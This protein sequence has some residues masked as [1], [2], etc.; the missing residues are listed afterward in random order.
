MNG[1]DVEMLGIGHTRG[2]GGN[3]KLSS[4]RKFRMREHATTKLAHAYRLDEIAASVATMQSAS[5]LEEVAKH[6]LVRNENDPEAQYVHFFHEKIPSRSM[7]ENTGLQPLTDI[8]H[9]R[10][11]E[12]AA[13]RTRAVTRIFKEDYLGSV[14]DLT[15]GLATQRLYHGHRSDQLELILARDAAKLAQGKLDENDYP[16]SMEPQLL[17]HRAGVHLTLACQN[18]VAALRGTDHYPGP[19]QDQGEPAPE[20]PQQKEEARARMEA[21][22]L[23]RTYA[24]RALRDYTSFLSHFDYS[25]GISAEFTDAFLDKVASMTTH[26]TSSNSSRSQRLLDV[27]AHSQ[28]GLSEALVKYERCRQNSS[29]TSDFPQIP[30]PPVYKISDLFNAVP[31][32]L[33]PFPPPTDK[34][35]PQHP[36]FSLPD[37]SEAVTYHPLLADVLHSLLLCHCLVQ[38][39]QKELQR[40]AYM[41]A[42]VARACD[43]YPIFL[44]ARSPSRADWTE[45]LRKIKSFLPLE[46]SWENLCQPATMK[47]R[48][49]DRDRIKRDAIRDALADERVV[50]EET[51]RAS[52]RAREARAIAAEDDDMSKE[53]NTISPTRDAKANRHSKTENKVSEKDFLVSTER[54]ELIARWIREAP[55]PGGDSS[56]GTRRRTKRNPQI[57]ALRKQ[58]SDMSAVSEGSV[59]SAASSTGLEQSLESLDM[60]D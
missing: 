47:V 24:K 59:I 33:P 23:V 6:V 26:Q 41:A 53:Y 37:F 16:S 48:K 8:I 25:P 20:S 54:A 57:R 58:A 14:R 43:G 13:Y 7:A 49:N 4:E 29:S 19:A 3:A 36:I 5:A 46:Q 27:D 51:F 12:V 52:V 17:F 56:I 10:P 18:V 34:G 35:E 15:E 39:S 42:R 44:P 11:S 2:G 28:N 21:R 50:D 1:A 30:K 31:P 45:L 22:K 55:P 40:H 32:T 38:T 9:Q 60:V